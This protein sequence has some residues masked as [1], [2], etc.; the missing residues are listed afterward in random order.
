MRSLPPTVESALA[1]FQTGGAVA[2]VA[3]RR[4]EFR[5]LA[6]DREADERALTE[7]NSPAVRRWVTAMLRRRM[8][9]A[10]VTGA[11]IYVEVKA[12]PHHRDGTAR[13][14]VEVTINGCGATRIMLAWESSHARGLA[15]WI[16][17]VGPAAAVM[18]DAADYRSEVPRA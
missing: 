14:R 15:D 11:S 3:H 16:D 2:G 7:A 13:A 17:D 12:I 18:L 6:Y 9:R 8:E 4:S 10:G 5:S 1:A